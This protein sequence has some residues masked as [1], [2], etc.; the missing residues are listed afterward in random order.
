MNISKTN[1]RIFLCSVTSSILFLSLLC[2]FV[3]VEKNTRYVAFGDNSP[4]FVY[5]YSH[6]NKMFIKLHFMGRDYIFSRG[7]TV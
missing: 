4:F 2:G 6:L 5:K 1:I 7:Q 3:I